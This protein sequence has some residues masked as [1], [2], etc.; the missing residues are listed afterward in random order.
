LRDL[1]TSFSDAVD[2]LE[3]KRNARGSAIAAELTRLLDSMDAHVLEA[4]RLFNVESDA[5]DD[6]LRQGLSPFLD[7]VGEEV[8][9]QVIRGVTEKYRAHT[10]VG[11]VLAHL[12]D[13]AK[14]WRDL[15]AGQPTASVAFSLAA[16]S[17]DIAREASTLS[18]KSRIPEIS[19]LSVELR[20]IAKRLGTAAGNLE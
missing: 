1:A 10:D 19:S 3:E 11:V 2:R 15:L 16:L 5:R 17:P 7:G 4:R 14:T 9:E 20:A 12:E 18:A 13:S 8:G 6:S